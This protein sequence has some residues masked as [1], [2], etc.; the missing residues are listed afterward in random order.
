MAKHDTLLRASTPHWM[1]SQGSRA[2]LC[3][4]EHW[5]WHELCVAARCQAYTRQSWKD[6]SNLLRQR[7]DERTWASENTRWVSVTN[8]STGIGEGWGDEVFT[9][10]GLRQTLKPLEV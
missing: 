6:T 2:N 7:C 8:H 3:H 10:S 9:W 4:V 5:Y 1:M